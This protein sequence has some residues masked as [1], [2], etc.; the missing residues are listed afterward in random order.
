MNKKTEKN[1]AAGKTKEI[2]D[3]IEAAFG[4]I[5]DFFKAL[6]AVDE[7]WLELNWNRLQ[8]I[9]LSEGGL[10]HK[11][12][13]LIALAVS[14]V[15]RCKYCCSA[16]ETMARAAGATDQEIGQVLQVVDLFSSFNVIVD[17]LGLE[18]DIKPE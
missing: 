14:Q 16:H 10:D 2:F 4:M 5:P 15:N 1:E 6:A 12:R 7:N 8:K 3:E 18:P 9:M 11:T 13:E 17:A